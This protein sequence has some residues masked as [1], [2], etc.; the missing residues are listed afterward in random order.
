MTWLPRSPLKSCHLSEENDSGRLEQAVSSIVSKVKKLVRMIVI[1]L[2]CQGFQS[3]FN[4]LT[5]F[6][7][8][9]QRLQSQRSLF[10]G[11]AQCN[12]RL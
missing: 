1:I 9:R 5:H 11:I 4:P 8:L 7:I 10:V 2:F 3:Q 6:N 12:Q